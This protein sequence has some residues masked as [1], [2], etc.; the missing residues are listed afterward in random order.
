MSV[1]VRPYRRGGWEVDITIRL[2]DGSRW[3]ERSKAPGS[4]KSAA[5][6]SAEDRERHV[7]Q[8]GM[9]E[10]KK[11]VPRLEQFAPRCAAGHARANRQKPSGNAA[12]EA[13]LRK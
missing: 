13:D 7:L 11:E 12:N 5:A 1:K 4:S 10:P 3:R 8:H 6:R 9:R 2:P